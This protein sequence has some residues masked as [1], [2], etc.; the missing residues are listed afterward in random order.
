M[1]PALPLDPLQPAQL[2]VGLVH[3]VGGA[4]RMIGTLAGQ[5]PVRHA[6]QLVIELA[7]EVV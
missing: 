5:L 6:P 1:R 4:E 2:Q 7:R 3:Q